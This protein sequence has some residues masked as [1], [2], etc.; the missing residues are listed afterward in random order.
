MSVCVVVCVFGGLGNH[1]ALLSNERREGP[2]VQGRWEES[3]GIGSGHGGMW[4]TSVGYG[5]WSAACGLAEGGGRVK[6]FTQL[7]QVFILSSPTCSVRC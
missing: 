7:L 5:A 1:C 2:P 4:G 3:S 6:L